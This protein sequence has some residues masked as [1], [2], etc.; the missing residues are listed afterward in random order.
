MLSNTNLS[1]AVGTIDDKNATLIY[2][3]RR[4]NPSN[5]TL[6]YSNRVVNNLIVTTTLQAVLVTSVVAFHVTRAI[7]RRIRSEESN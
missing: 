6:V 7:V 1:S 4:E 2:D 5:V 3:E